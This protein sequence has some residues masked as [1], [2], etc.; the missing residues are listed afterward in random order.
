MAPLPVIT[1]LGENFVRCFVNK[2]MMLKLVRI[3]SIFLCVVKAE[4]GCQQGHFPF[5]IV[6]VS[7]NIIIHVIMYSDA[8][9]RKRQNL[10]IYTAFV[11]KGVLERIEDSSVCPLPITLPAIAR[12]RQSK[13]K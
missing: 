3:P 13:K 2:V 5:R 8:V 1:G 12:T 9:L 11:F 10:H 4:G 7:I 6:Q